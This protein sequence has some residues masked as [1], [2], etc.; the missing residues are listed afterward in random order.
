MPDELVDKPN[1]C[2]VC[3]ARSR[4]IAFAGLWYY[5]RRCSSVQRSEISALDTPIHPDLM[6][7]QTC[8]EDAVKPWRNWVPLECSSQ[9][10]FLW[11]LSFDRWWFVVDCPSVEFILRLPCYNFQFLL[12]TSP[13]AVGK[14]FD[15]IRL[16]HLISRRLLK[17]SEGIALAGRF[18][19]LILD[20]RPRHSWRRSC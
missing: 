4:N 20:R 6:P 19:V 3:F 1:C 11:A 18:L 15:P 5:Y 12:A 14:S 7:F 17:C 10:C 8:P 13:S 2:T 16:D 9:R